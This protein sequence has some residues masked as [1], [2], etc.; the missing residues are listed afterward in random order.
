MAIRYAFAAL[1]TMQ[2]AW[3]FDQ[4]APSGVL[5]Y[6]TYLCDGFGA[7]TEPWQPPKPSRHFQIFHGFPSKE[8]ER[9]GQKY[10]TQ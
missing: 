3:S 10:S 1:L 2:A 4:P 9:S 6:S 7:K 8:S 5:A